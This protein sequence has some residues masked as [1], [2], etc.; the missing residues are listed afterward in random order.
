MNADN[1][2]EDIVDDAS[3]A[4]SD[5]VEPIMKVLYSAHCVQP[6]RLTFSAAPS[7]CKMSLY[8]GI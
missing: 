6:L 5:L 7:R 8:D 1:T 4:R 2:E 3:M